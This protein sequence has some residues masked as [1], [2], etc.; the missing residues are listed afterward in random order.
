MALAFLA[1]ISD[2]AF[3][4]TSVPSFSHFTAYFNLDRRYSSHIDEDIQSAKSSGVK[5]T[6]TFFIKEYRYNGAWDLDS[7][8]SALDE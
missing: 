7:L 1:I 2:C 3:N 8:L 5:S 6:P 4:M